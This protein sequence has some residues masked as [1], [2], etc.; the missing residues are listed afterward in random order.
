MTPAARVR[1]DSGRNPTQGLPRSAGNVARMLLA[2]QELCLA[3]ADA[4]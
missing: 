4:L 3:R 2:C 1:I